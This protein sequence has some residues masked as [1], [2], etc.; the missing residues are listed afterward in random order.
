MGAGPYARDPVP[1][2]DVP[3]RTAADGVVPDGG[4]LQGD[5]LRL[6]DNRTYAL[7]VLANTP[8]DVRAVLQA[9]PQRRPYVMLDGGANL[10]PDL[11][12]STFLIDGGWYGV[13]DPDLSDEDTVD[14]RIEG[15]A[16]ADPEDYDF[17]RVEIRFATLDPGGLRA[18]GVR[19][20]PLRLLVRARVRRLVIR[21]SIVGPVHV[22]RENPD[23]PSMVEELLICE[24]VVD[25]RE[26][27]D[28][29]AVS[30]NFGTVVIEGSTIFGDVRADVLR[31]SDTIVDGRVRVV[32]NQAGCFR[33]SAS[34]PGAGVRL[35]PRYR[36][37]LAPISEAAF[38]S[39]R[40][41]DPQY[42]QLSVVAP[43]QLARGAENG[44]E[45][46][47]FSHLLAPIRLSSVR[48]KVGEFGPVGMLAQY[49]FEGDYRAESLV[50]FGLLSPA[51]EEADPPPPPDPGDLIPEPEPPEPEPLPTTCDDVDDT[52]VTILPPPAAPRVEIDLGAADL[53]G[54][55]DFWRGLDW[56]EDLF[57]APAEGRRPRGIPFDRVRV[58]IEYD[59]RFGTMPAEQGWR[60]SGEEVKDFYELDGRRALRFKI[61][62]RP[63]F[64]TAEAELEKWPPAQLH[65]YVN[66]RLD[67]PPEAL[68][69][70][71][72]GFTQLV[73]ANLAGKPFHGLRADWSK[74]RGRGDLHYL[75][76]DGRTVVGSPVPPRRV[77]PEWRKLSLQAGFFHDAGRRGWLPKL[78]PERAGDAERL[79]ELAELW[80]KHVG[81]ALVS[82]DEQ[83]EEFKL[84]EFGETQGGFDRATLRAVFGLT[85][86]EGRAAGSLRN[87]VAS[88]PG[89]YIRA[90][91]RA[92]SPSPSPVLELGFVAQEATRAGA[93]FRVR[94]GRERAGDTALPLRIAEGT[95]KLDGEKASLRLP[96]RAVRARDPLVITLERDSL[97][98]DDT[99]E[100]SV[101]LVSAALVGAGG[102]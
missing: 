60:A 58:L 100:A 93:R 37:L 20:P 61:E 68:R 48:A 47:V 42:A 4:V 23:D 56:R 36:D 15:A 2:A 102:R 51:P 97:H 95:L 38:N 81:R 89:R 71:A 87:F 14:F 78:T 74:G 70:S 9:G 12:D 77:P 11:I 96:L 6:A 52:T 82:L 72:E 79:K 10:T 16:G 88:A 44:S 91:M 83:V 18:D 19:L 8:V 85:R 46:G 24:S 67:E 32:N 28:R 53:N 43:P 17:Q 63:A 33:F 40:F 75:S 29:L 86:K 73:E 21:R 25:A 49:L 80:D 34:E 54:A 41:G 3:T 99:L 22:V 50:R 45:M 59:A 13:N 66:V 35:P 94:Y 62:G 92:E 98:P 26:T 5:G 76:L 64:F 1:A 65:A 57:P 31:A 55:P 30:S 69:E 7:S 84:K 39:T 27:A 90:W 101:R